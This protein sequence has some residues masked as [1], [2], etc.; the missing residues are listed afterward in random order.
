M[1]RDGRRGRDVEWNESMKVATA[2][3]C[4]NSA[5]SAMAGKS[6]SQP[7]IV[8]VRREV[9]GELPHPL[10]PAKARTRG[11]ELDSRLRGNEREIAKNA[12]L[13]VLLQNPLGLGLR[14][15]HCLL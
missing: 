15:L 13:S 12:P 8:A 1:N 4:V 2:G 9:M 14:V 7:W 3:Q 5:S 11:L 10:V 6:R